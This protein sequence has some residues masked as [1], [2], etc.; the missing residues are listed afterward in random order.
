MT[1]K[2]I[3]LKYSLALTEVFSFKPARQ[4]VEG[5]HGDISYVLNVEDLIPRFFVS[6]IQ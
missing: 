4:F 1:Q 2:S 6:Q 5:Q 3:D